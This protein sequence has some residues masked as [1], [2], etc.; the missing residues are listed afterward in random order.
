MF[1]DIKAILLLMLEVLHKRKWLI[2]GIT[3]L[4]IGIAGYRFSKQPKVYEA[5]SSVLVD[6][7]SP[8]YLGDNIKD[9]QPEAYPWFD[10]QILDTEL[11]V[12]GSEGTAMAAAKT[13]CEKRVGLERTIP[14]QKLIP[15]ASC[16]NP[17]DLERAALLVQGMV[18]A[19]VIKNTRVIK[20]IAQGRDPEVT[21]MVANATARGYVELNMEQRLSA[22]KGAASWLSGEYRNLISQVNAAESSLIDFKKANNILAVSIEDLQNTL[23][24]KHKRLA[25][26]LNNVSLK[27]IALRAQRDQYA[28]LQSDDPLNDVPFGAV[29]NGSMEKLKELYVDQYARLLEL[30]NKY[31]ENHP[32]LQ[33]QEAR[34]EAI[35]SDVKREA[36]LALKNA[37]AQYQAA[38]RQEADLRSA[39]DAATKEALELEQRSTEYNRL[40]SNY[41]R[42]KSLTEQVGGRERETSLAA[43]LNTNNVRILDIA[44]APR[45]PIEPN[46]P[47]SLGFAF[48]I[49][50]SLSLGLA[51][52]LELLDSTV[53]TPEDIEKSLGVPFLGLI[54]SIR[55]GRTLDDE[56]PLMPVGELARAGSKDLFILAEPQSIVAECCR[57]VRTNLLFMCPDKPAK[58]LLFTSENVGEGK[59]TAAINVAITLAQSGLRV[60]LVDSDMRRPRLHKAFGI[61]ATPEGLSKAIVGEGN[62]LGYVRE[63]GLPGL[64][65]LPAGAIPPNPSELLHAERFKQLVAELNEHY[66]RLVFDSPPIHLVT[67]ATIL[68][69]LTDATVLVAKHGV[70]SKFG[71]ARIHRAL[72]DGGVNVMGC[73]FNDYDL[74]RRG[75]YRYHFGKYGYYNRYEPAAEPAH[76]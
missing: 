3:V 23:T 30:R 25:E 39:L 7:S 40:K 13:L 51:Y 50:L 63:T 52:L 49:G 41:D 57:A 76:R 65:L 27:L 48:A 71:L 17:G 32:T 66:D 59:T 33:A 75:K 9:A 64:S 1:P 42:L 29:D 38:L 6:L 43:R 67:D 68:S 18:R 21:A 62:A 2:L 60:L 34:V 72:V 12:V 54:P 69:R 58:S 37:E 61:P 47:Q 5:T 24:S 35:K 28:A 53:K 26:E 10:S 8:R 45:T 11:K 74:S 14:I 20:L 22:N 16:D 55:P 70:T 36:G 15:G 19:S 4:S 73:I 46:V 56:P 44:R 31:R